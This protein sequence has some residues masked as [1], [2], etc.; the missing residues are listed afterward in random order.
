MKNIRIDRRTVL[1]FGGASALLAAA[2]SL[3]GCQKREPESGVA[4]NGLK[5]LSMQS[6]WI[7]DAEFIGYFIGLT[8]GYYRDQGLDYQYLSGGPTKVADQVLATRNA[9]V[10]LTNPETTVNM[11]L[12]EK[13]PFK[14]IGTQYQ[15][16]PLGVVSLAKNKITSPKDLI[17]RRVAV[18][19]ANQIT[20]DAFLRLNQVD[21]KSVKTVPYAYDPTPLVEGKVDATV[22]FVTNVPFSIRQAGE[23]PSSF[24]FYDFGFKV[25]M[26]TVVVLEETIAS[27]RDALV[28]FLRASRKGWVE[29]FADPE[30]WPPQF[31]KTHFAG[32]NRTVENEIYFNRAQYP[33]MQ[34]PQGYFSMNEDDIKGTIE[35]LNSIGLKATREMF[36][37]SL[38]GQV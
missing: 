25:F 34:A 11:I 32:T 20:L 10:A 35:S 19:D 30:K 21:P 29:N 23:E 37:T 7:N 26:D 6:P 28:G 36:D 33:L 16:S 2:G 22:D 24:L 12:K 9:M 3:I 17:G 5:P 38:L 18:P 8:N 15:K 27:S 1:A 14:I 13:I 4:A 31:M